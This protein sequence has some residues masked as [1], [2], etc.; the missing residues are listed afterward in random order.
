MTRIEHYVAGGRGTFM[1]SSLVQDAVLWNLQLLCAATIKVSDSLKSE[2][3]QIDWWHISGLFRGLTR[4]PWHVDAE[5]VWQCVETDLPPVR[6][7][8]AGILRPT[9]GQHV[10]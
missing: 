3:R 6:R 2:Q 4:D 7:T 5:A 8:L 9:T 1:N 10:A